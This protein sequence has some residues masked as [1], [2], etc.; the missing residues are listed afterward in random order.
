MAPADGPETSSGPKT[1]DG[2]VVEIIMEVGSHLED[3]HDLGS[4]A[5]PD[6]CIR[7]FGAIK[8]HEDQFPERGGRLLRGHRVHLFPGRGPRPKE[9]D[10]LAT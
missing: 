4:V 7:D 5:A 6:R 9:R 8:S 1:D 10:S 2:P 3:R